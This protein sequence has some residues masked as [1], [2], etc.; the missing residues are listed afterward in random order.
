L[1]QL[2]ALIGRFMLA[3]LGF[4]LAITA[5]GVF[6]HLPLLPVLGSPYED[7]RLM[8]LGGMAVSLPF[9]VA[10]IGYYA[11]VPTA[12]L[13]AAAE[14]FGWR[15]FLFYVLAGAVIGLVASFA[16]RTGDAA[17]QQ[18]PA[19]AETLLAIVAAG[20]IAG[21]VY[22]LVAGRSAGRWRLVD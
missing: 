20:M 15:G 11:L 18:P 12:L 1:D 9:L 8:A 13:V 19:S 22:W 6:L 14:W 21:L 5:A 3:S 7:E 10:V 17:A 2:L 16:S 4:L